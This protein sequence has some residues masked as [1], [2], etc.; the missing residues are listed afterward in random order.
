VETDE[1][2]AEGERRRMEDDSR[3]LQKRHRLPSAKNESRYLLA[4]SLNPAK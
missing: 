3:N 2:E 4:T 1:K